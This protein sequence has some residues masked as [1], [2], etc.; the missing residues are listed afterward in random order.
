MTTYNARDYLSVALES[1]I[2][3]GDDGIE[4]IVV[5]DGSTDD[6]LEILG[7]YRSRLDMKLIVRE[8][9][10]NWVASMNLGMRAATGDYVSFLHHDDHWLPGR[11]SALRAA[12]SLDP[13]AVL[14]VHPS[15]Y[16]NSR[17]E[18]LGVWRCAL[19]RGRGLAPD[20]VVER[21][22]VQNFI[23]V[24]GPLFRRDAGLAVGGLDEALW[25]SA[26]WDF[27]LK[28]AAAGQTVYLPQPYSA[29]RI[30]P[31]ASTWRDTDRVERVWHQ[32]N[33]VLNRHI[34]HRE[35][36]RPVRI[37]VRRVARFSRDVN[38]L[39]AA[40]AHGQRPGLDLAAL[41]LRFVALGPLGWHRYLR[42]SRILERASARVRAGMLHWS[43]A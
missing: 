18:P 17:G 27:W 5:D 35:S 12:V 10:G 30:H 42:N 13:D 24:P 7:R 32:L 11:V 34:A 1:I 33:A 16:I 19:D 39:L 25:Y 14:V 41:A 4:V 40:S 36:F 20:D 2:S 3:Q 29:Y 43:H 23:A 28:L 15:L 8:H 9:S 38:T 31:V 6:T 26:D 21:L 22:L 37:G